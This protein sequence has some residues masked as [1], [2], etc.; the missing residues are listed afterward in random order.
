MCE[1]PYVIDLVSSRAARSYPA[2][3]SLWEEEIE[4]IRLGIE[5]HQMTLRTQEIRRRGGGQDR[6]RVHDDTEQKKDRRLLHSVAIFGS[7]GS[8]KSSLLRT[9]CQRYRE[10]KNDEGRAFEKGETRPT[11]SEVVP[12]DLIQPTLFSDHDNFLYAFFANALEA[13]A[14]RRKELN[15]DDL[16]TQI[17][18]PVEQAFHEAS[19]Y[20]QVVNP[21]TSR[22]GADALG[23]SLEQLER[24]T[25]SLRLKQKVDHFLD[26]LVGSLA[27]PGPDALLLLPVDDA[28]MSFKGLLQVLEMYHRYLLH[29][30]L[31]PVF[32]FSSRLAEEMLIGHFED[33]IAQARDSH[34]LG[35]AA[36]DLSLPESLALQF[37]SKLFPVRNRIRMGSAPARVQQAVVRINSAEFL[38]RERP[39]FDVRELLE[40]S[41]ALLFGTAEWPQVERIRQPLRPSTLRRQI[42]ILDAL[43]AANAHQYVTA[44]PGGPRGEG[45]DRCPGSNA[46]GIPQ[47]PEANDSARSPKA[48]SAVF[49]QV[50]WSMLSA[51]RDVLKEMDLHLEDLYSWSRSNLRAV[52]LDGILSQRLESRR[53]FLQR[54]RTRTDDRRGFILSLLAANAFRPSMHENEGERHGHPHSVSTRKMLIWFV[55]L[56]MGFY[57]P[58]TLARHRKNAQNNT[59]PDVPVVRAEGWTL[60]ASATQ[61]MR[62]ILSNEQIFTPGTLLVDVEATARI[63][64]PEEPT[65][66][67]N[68]LLLEIWGN[69]GYEHGVPWAAVS[70]W[71]GLTLAARLLENDVRV[72][73]EIEGEPKAQE[74]DASGERSAAAKEWIREETERRRKKYI[75]ETLRKQLDDFLIQGTVRRQATKPPDAYM[76]A[77]KLRRERPSLGDGSPEA[78][79]VEQIMG[80]VDLFHPTAFRIEPLQF[81]RGAG[82]DRWKECVL[83]KLHA[84]DLLGVYW[85][86]LQTDFFRQPAKCW[87][88]ADLLAGS[89]GVTLRYLAVETYESDRQK[90]SQGKSAFQRSLLVQLLG[91]CPFIYPLLASSDRDEIDRWWTSPAGEK[92]RNNRLEIGQ[93]RQLPYL[94]ARSEGEPALQDLRRVRFPDSPFFDDTELV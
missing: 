62:E 32:T 36:T 66:G 51:H 6:R 11:L 10:T 24:H 74:K 29:P 73:R 42:Q 43:V 85:S 7:F 72:L 64:N 60:R 77:A 53:R 19:E 47:R 31:V 26:R 86:R 90:I 14:R 44:L 49:D 81:E 78:L 13:D 79:L 25:S 89:L 70:L 61:A 12:L 94:G 28:D 87:T 18:S 23:M 80:W 17:L 55:D 34:V 69:A 33:Q 92:A 84:N 22:H 57:L 41:S 4:R 3:E 58:Q 27:G 52:V 8:G 16:Q 30:Q 71:R 20:L 54:W 48:W 88:G 40:I 56:W 39:T 67:W 50:A 38:P 91:T 37:L 93:H 68:Q 9:L 46:Y 65:S 2:D 82:E 21:Q 1:R 5:D 76:N 63:L 75:E 83:R 35:E 45:T 15:P 59:D